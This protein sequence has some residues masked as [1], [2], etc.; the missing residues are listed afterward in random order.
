MKGISM[1]CIKNLHTLCT[2]DHSRMEVGIL[3]YKNVYGNQV[4]SLFDFSIPD[5][6]DLQDFN[7]IVLCVIHDTSSM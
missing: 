2:D 6:V 1:A 4:V 5:C 3:Y 7:S